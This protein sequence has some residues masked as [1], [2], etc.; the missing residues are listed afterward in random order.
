MNPTAIITG[1]SSGI[2]RSLAHHLGTKSCRT[3]YN[4]ALLGRNM[5]ELEKTRS[6]ISSSNINNSQNQCCNLY[7]CDLTN[8][9]ELKNTILDICDNFG[10][11]TLVINSAAMANSG[12]MLDNPESQTSNSFEFKNISTWN[13]M[14]D[15][16]LK[17][18]IQVCYYSLPYLKANSDYKGNDNTNSKFSNCAIINIGSISSHDS[19]IGRNKSIYA[20]TKFGVRGF[21]NCLY[22]D[23][24]N[25]NIKVSC[26][27]PQFTNTEMI[28]K[29]ERNRVLLPHAQEMVQVEDIA[30]TVDYIL[31]FSQSACPTEVI[32]KTQ[33]D[34][35]KYL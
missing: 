32:I 6:L 24:R 20:A 7:P 13:E 19:A 5:K 34:L 35:T 2:G 4:L 33:Q 25:Y 14:V 10:P 8:E 26:I 1:A 30:N 11:L 18:L 17:S 16:N 12:S 22:E 27:M 29:I 28:D 9:T 23:V 21:S 15:L 31:N 3:P